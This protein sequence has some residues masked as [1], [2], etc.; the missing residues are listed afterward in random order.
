MTQAPTLG[1][2]SGASSAGTVS[3]PTP[4]T[5]TVVAGSGL[6][7]QI[8]LL[9]SSGAVTS[10]T[11]S[12]GGTYTMLT[13]GTSGTS[14]KT[15]I[16]RRLGL[17]SASTTFSVT[18]GFNAATYPVE[19]AVI[20]ILGDGGVDVIGTVSTGV[21]T[22]ESASLTSLDPDD[23]VLFLGAD[24]SAPSNFH[25]W[26]TGQSGITGYPSPPT[27]LTGF[28]STQ[29]LT[30]AGSLTSSRI[31]TA[32]TTWIGVSIAISP[33]NLWSNILDRPFVTVSPIGQAATGYFNGGADF[34]IDTPGTQTYGIQEALNSI[35]SSGGKVFCLQGA[36]S[37]SSAFA[38][39]GSY[40]ILEF[41]PGSTVTFANALTGIRPNWTHTVKWEL[42]Y[43]LILMGAPAISSN[44]APYSHQWFIGNGVQIY[45]GSNQSVTGFQIASPGPQ[46]T[47]NYTGNGGVDFLIEGVVSSG[48]ISECFGV[49]A[50]YQ[51]TT[52]VTTLQKTR[53]IIVRHFYDTRGANTAGGSGFAVGGNV[54][55][56]LI[57]DVEIDLSQASGGGGLSN[58]FIG[59]WQGET[60][61]VVVRRCWFR[62]GGSQSQPNGSQVLEL[63]GNGLVSTNTDGCHDITIEDTVF[64][65]GATSGSPFGGE[66]GA[67][68]D[69]NNG[70]GGGGAIN[71]VTFKNCLW[72]FC[73]LNF[74]SG[75]STPG[76]IIFYGAMPGAFSG[77]LQGRPVLQAPNLAASGQASSGLQ[78]P[79]L[80]G[81]TLATIATY[82]PP[83]GTLGQFRVN[84]YV[85]CLS[86]DTFTIK[87]AYY[88]PSVGA[89]L[90]FAASQ[91]LTTNESWNAVYTIV[92]SSGAAIVVYGGAA[93]SSTTLVGSAT[94]DQVG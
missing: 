45:W 60:S 91:A 21:G 30:P 81:S 35:A 26:G 61:N 79:L 64:D 42:A 93:S 62:D 8:N 37:L 88:D 67:Y 59:G 87:V 2:V 13:H 28:G 77:S 56:M 89:A 11:D 49:H 58:C 92:A 9:S 34:G 48:E 85:V 47:N 57:E 29:K 6:Y 76:F 66:G 43:C 3:L 10:I 82:T 5:Q 12:Q 25:N 36:Y 39:T 69:D 80:T 84:V 46:S 23:F 16:Y 63:Q 4:A 22:T 83:T 20:P 73:G 54:F 75:G 14:L 19:V 15:F 51:N 55:D 71:R 70:N 90:V 68:I 32:S 50:Q 33:A 72:N 86:P 65:S 52:G 41:A 53:H 27:G 17:L 40:Q 74:L 44:P 94:I 18:V 31:V 78:V 7:V 24:T 1:A 38:F